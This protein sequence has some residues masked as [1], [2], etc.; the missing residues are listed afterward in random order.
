MFGLYVLNDFFFLISNLDKSWF[1]I[2][3]IKINSNKWGCL[4][5]H[6]LVLIDHMQNTLYCN[7]SITVYCSTIYPIQLSHVTPPS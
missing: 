6:G 7:V 1:S 3:I 2:S 4:D 5:F